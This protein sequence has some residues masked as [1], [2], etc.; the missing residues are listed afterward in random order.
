VS[1]AFEREPPYA[2][3]IAAVCA[4][5][6]GMAFGG[7]VN[8]S[9]FL[10]PLAAEFGWPRAQI[11]AAYSVATVASGLGGIVMGYFS[12]R[13]PIRRMVLAGAL[14]PGAAFFL[15]AGL[16]SPAELYAWHALM[17]LFG[18]AVILVPLNNLTTFWFARNRGLA[19]GIVSAGGALGQ[20]LMPFLAR[21]LIL[22]QGWREAYQS[23]G[24]LYFA[25]LVPL[26]LLLR[27]PPAAADAMAAAT[28]QARNPYALP[29]PALVAI[30]CV[31]VV[32]CCL[33]M[34]TPIVHVVALGTDHGL[35]PREAAGLLTVMM[36]FGV[37]G[38]LLT[39]A[40][41][42]RIGNLRAYF[43]VS[44]AQTALALW[45]PY[46]HSA[47]GLY[48]LAAL[49]GLWY[50]GVMTA[51]ILCAREFAPPRYGGLAMGLVAFSGWVGMALG[52]W[53]GGLFFDLNGDYFQSFLNSS[54]AG[55]VNLLLL[56]LLYGYTDPRAL[57]GRRV[58][59]AA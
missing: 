28:G 39:G 16:D 38:R 52:A 57:R 21:H 41:A 59:A 44:L 14:V 9:V 12:D 36:L 48:A 25:A 32:F 56:G 29:R 51:L 53:Q 24:I 45:F 43:V 20:G 40:M 6:V 46:L 11:A 17:G 3:V 55:V 50:A 34:S 54:I 23:L 42:D 18:F 7:L 58:L 1:A 26:A 8:I 5:M 15:L 19:I 10:K 33:C 30:L 49:F 22:E 35:G 37:A 2:W 4:V 31:A 27:N 13:L 47:A